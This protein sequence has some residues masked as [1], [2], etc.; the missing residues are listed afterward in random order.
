M[1]NRSADF[2][3]A[4][5]DA[6]DISSEVAT[7]TLDVRDLGP[8]K[9]LQQ[10]LEWLADTDDETVLVQINDRA[11]QHLYPKLG[12]RGYEYHTAELQDAVV[13]AIWN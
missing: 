2:E 11:P 5:L 7:E 4:A 10:T 9:P 8:P 13:T 12:D 1:A 3:T 6:A